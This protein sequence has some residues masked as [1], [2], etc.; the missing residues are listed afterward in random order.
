M[1]ELFA[2]SARRPANIRLSLSELATHGGVVGPHR[3]GCGVAFYDETDVRCFREVGP[4]EGSKLLAMLERHDYLSHTT[5]VHLRKAI[6]GGRALKNTQP[7]LR[8]FGG[9]MHSFTHNGMLSGIEAAEPLSRFLPVG[10]TDSEHAFCVLMGAMA[11]L[12]R[13]RAIPALELRLQ[14][15]TTFAQRVRA[16]GPAN[17][18]YSDGD[19]LFVHADQRTQ[20]DGLVAPPG[21]YMLNRR[22]SEHGQL[23]T[24]APIKLRQQASD[25]AVTL[26]ASVPLTEEG[27]S[28][29]QRGEVVVARQGVVGVR[30]V[31]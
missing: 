4:V 23:P 31:G 22:C 18:I 12:W 20:D 13:G 5:L 14:V 29:L 17:F 8:E 7:F 10:D 30:V 9:R 27:W 28:P 6:Q 26:F 16:L 19:A 1:C 15:F 24:M 11:E 2:M 21:L 3:D 25:Q